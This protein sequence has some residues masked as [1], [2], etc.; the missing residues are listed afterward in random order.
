MKRRVTPGSVIKS[1]LIIA[2]AV[3]AAVLLANIVAFL[4]SRDMVPD[5][6]RMSGVDISSLSITDAINRT[7]RMLQAPV[8][9]RYRD[10]IIQ[11]PPEQVEFQ[12]SDVVARLQLTKLVDSKR[13]LDQFPDFVLRRRTEISMT[14][15]YQYS[16]Q[17]LVEFLDK[18]A[19]E[20]D[21]SPI[22]AQPD[23]NK[24]TLASGQNGQALDRADSIALIVSALASSESRFVDLPVDIVP[25]EKTRLGDLGE[26]IKQRIA[27]YTSG[28]NV[29]GVFVKDISNGE[30]FGLN[31]DVAFSGQGW[32][33]LALVVEAY[34]AAGATVDPTLTQQLA[35][36]IASGNA[37]EPNDLLR[38]LGQGDSQTG[39]N[40][41]NATLKRLGLVSTFLA[42]PYGQPSA[43]A[44]FITP[45]NARLDA[46]T[47][48]DPNAQSTPAEV[49]LLMEMLEQCRTNTGALP[50][51]FP[52][53]YNSARCDLVLQTLG[54]NGA[55]ILLAAGSAGAPT[56]HRQSWDAYNHGDVALV[57]SPGGTYVVAVM[58]HSASPL[59]WTETSVVI[60][61]IGRAAYGFFNKDQVPPPVAALNAPPPQ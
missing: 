7:S 60:S 38:S 14:A 23:I 31:A 26:L 29:A 25:G 54:Q 16:E 3:I 42:Q 52:G 32:L 20:H 37:Q 50:L 12:V 39:V 9:L 41:L 40:Q 35:A 24:L 43:P 10:A 36:I 55:N 53:V 11:L 56:I 46:N 19:T 1:V 13:G 48:P 44:Q 4:S 18:V 33:R 51:V 49:S 27:L 34:R 30:E 47:A 45:G 6:T 5:E 61:D 15:P 17:K 59:S 57:R 58:L 8:A 2:G 21:Q 28:G 22:I